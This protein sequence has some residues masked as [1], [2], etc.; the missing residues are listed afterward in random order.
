[1]PKWITTKCVKMSYGW[2]YKSEGGLIRAKTERFSTPIEKL[3]ELLSSLENTCDLQQYTIKSVV[4]QTESLGCYDYS[5][6]NASSYGFG[7]GITQVTGFVVFLQR[8]EEISMAEYTRRNNMLRLKDDIQ[9]L[10][11]HVERIHQQINDEKARP[12]E[13]VEKK[14]MLGGMKYMIGDAS[15]DSQQEAAAFQNELFL[16]ISK[17]EAELA[18]MKRALADS[19][20]TYADERATLEDKTWDSV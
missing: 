5:T 2:H 18:D 10:T 9:S 7:Y 4:P 20:K 1:M 12:S 13:I 3:S 17:L 11:E 8:E 15:F 6:S 14:K 19:Q 16:K